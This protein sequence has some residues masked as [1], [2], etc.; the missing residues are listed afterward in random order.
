MSHMK[1]KKNKIENTITT[2]NRHKFPGKAAAITT[3]AIQ[4][5]VSIK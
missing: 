4:L 3:T 2:L 5:I 1:P